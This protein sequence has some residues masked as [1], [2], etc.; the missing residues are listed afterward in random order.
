MDLRFSL[1]AAIDWKMLQ[2]VWEM[3]LFKIDGKPVIVSQLII[4]FVLFLIGLVVVKVLTSIVA[5]A[6]ERQK[7]IT[8]QAAAMIERLVYYALLALLI[9]SL[10]Q[11]VGIPIA[12]LAFLGGALAIGVGFGAQN[13]INNFISG[14]IL[15]VEQPIRVNDMI[16]VDVHLGV[17]AA[18]NSRCTRII[19]TDGIDVLVPNSK[20]LENSVI[21]WTLTDDLVKSDVEVGIAYGSDVQLARKI[22]F[23]IAE[24]EARVVK[25]QPHQPKVFFN[26]FGDNSLVFNLYVWTR[27]KHVSQVLELKSDLRFDIDARFRDANIC[28]AF[29]QRDVHL[30]TL[31]PLE[32]RMIS[33]TSAS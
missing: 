7:R 8:L 30:D 23:E 22:L 33:D 11:A 29:P 16:E 12:S 14:L 9:A 27:A 18:V 4:A 31:K 25:L 21:N 2:H 1:L 3:E 28:I 13:I 24:A 10:M 32:V 6:V 20:L 19:R 5:S 15:L 17:I 26:S